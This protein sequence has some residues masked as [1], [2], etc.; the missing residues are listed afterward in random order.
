MKLSPISPKEK[1]FTLLELLLALSL[2]ALVVAGAGRFLSQAFS[3]AERQDVSAAVL[4]DL[5]R[6]QDKLSSQLRSVLLH[7][8]RQDLFFLALSENDESA[9]L[10]TTA[11]DSRLKLVGWG[12]VSDSLYY[13]EAELSLWQP[14]QEELPTAQL[15]LELGAEKI[16]PSL[17]DLSFSFDGGVSSWDSR[18][19]G[20]PG[21]VLLLF[22][23]SAGTQQELSVILPQGGEG[24]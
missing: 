7:P 12:A 8:E 13:L 4:A 5:G 1:G 18:T 3:L 23:T 22:T 10:F 16:A 24:Q 17:T 14:S 6:I 15:L 9:L 20:L 21:E 2:G 19:Q 11:A